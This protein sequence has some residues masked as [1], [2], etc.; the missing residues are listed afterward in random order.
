[1]LMAGPYR[2]QPDRYIDNFN[3]AGERTIV[4]IN[5]E[6]LGQRKDGTTFPPVRRQGNDEEGSVFVVTIQDPRAE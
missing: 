5:R 1:M 3:G 6:V 2:E 4:G